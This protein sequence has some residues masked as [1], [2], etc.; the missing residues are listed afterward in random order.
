MNHIYMDLPEDVLNNISIIDLLK[1]RETSKES[2]SR[3][4]VIINNKHFNIFGDRGVHKSITKKIKDITLHQ[5]LDKVQNFKFGDGQNLYS[6]YG[7][8]CVTGDF[9]QHHLGEY[10]APRFLRSII[11]IWTMPKDGEDPLKPYFLKLIML[12][13]QR[14]LFLEQLPKFKNEIMNGYYNAIGNAIKRK[15]RYT[16]WCDPT[17]DEN[18]HYNTAKEGTDILEAVIET[19]P[20]FDKKDYERAIATGIN[21]KNLKNHILDVS[22][23]NKLSDELK[24]NQHRDSLLINLEGTTLTGLHGI[25]SLR[26]SPYF[27]EIYIKGPIS[28]I[29]SRLR[30][31]IDN[32]PKL[33][34]EDRGIL[35]EYHNFKIKSQ[36]FI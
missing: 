9:D 32:H 2:R 26:A 20:L 14:N 5:A 31:I 6:Q 13:E 10:I 24:R 33:T 34:D 4:D 11:Q 15:L 3:I 8:L 19:D 1:L 17:H 18:G 30:F 28:R 12:I 21:T 16:M 35:R 29:V 36:L 25:I 27:E 23:Y 22:G 7:M